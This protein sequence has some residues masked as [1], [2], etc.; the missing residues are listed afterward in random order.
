MGL[1]AEGIRLGIG[2]G[3]TEKTTTEAKQTNEVVVQGSSSDALCYSRLRKRLINLCSQILLFNLYLTC[4][5]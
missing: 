1:Q 2:K 3:P 4:W 5:Y